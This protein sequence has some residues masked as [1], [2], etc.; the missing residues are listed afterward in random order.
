MT[1]FGKM[2]RKERKERG[3]TLADMAAGLG[4]SSPYLSQL[5]TGTKPIKSTFVTKVASFFEFNQTDAA[6]LQR[7]AAHSVPASADSVTI[8]LTPDLSKR[9]R[10]L[11]SNFAMSFN[12]LKPETRDKI[13]RML[14]DASNG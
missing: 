6:A 7:A 5:E 1:P 4:I 9:D 3:M 13:R 8:D 12:R 11:A 14:K 10:E 2:L